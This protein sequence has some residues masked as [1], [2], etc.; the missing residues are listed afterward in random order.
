MIALLDVNVLV[1][2]F[3]EAHL[4][5]ERAHE[6]FG[7]NRSLGWASCPLTENGF[8]RVVSNPAYPGRGTTLQDAIARLERFRLSGGDHSFWPDS[9]SLRDD[10]LFR[11]VHI[12][13]HR[14]LTD[15]YLLA[16]A[17]RHRGR[18][19]TF[20]RSIPLRSVAGAGPEHLAIL[21]G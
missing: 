1:A 17:V 12:G 7:S 5:H 10:T 2:L 14:Q 8:A 9:V 19:A 13:G 15:L 21:G 11:L 4:H 18:L 20:D 16:L 6:W 3:D